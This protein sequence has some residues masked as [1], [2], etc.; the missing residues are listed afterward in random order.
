MQ[1]SANFIMNHTFICQCFRCLN[2]KT[3]SNG[4]HTHT[5]TH[6]LIL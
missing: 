1:S 6:T 3:L 2:F 4:L 5:H